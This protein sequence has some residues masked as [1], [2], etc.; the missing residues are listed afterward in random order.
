MDVAL[1]DSDILNKLAGRTNVIL[2]RYL[3]G[4]S[5]IEQILI[6]DSCVI[7]YE[8][9]NKVGHWVCLVRYFD[10]HTGRWTIEFFDSY[11]LF[12]ES[13]KT[14]INRPFLKNSGQ[15]NNMIARL[16][17]K[18]MNDGYNIAYNDHLQQSRSKNI[19]TCGRHVISRILNKHMTTDE[20]NQYIS[21][22]RVK[23]RGKIRR[24]TPDQAVIY[25]TS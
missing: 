5:N 20:Y 15:R 16:L 22:F 12:P 3:A 8:T 4:V 25:L 1:S 6:N 19:S 14:F 23:F 9:K 2:Y 11:G 18:A 17:Y 13:E 24:L 21:S 7:L 10:N